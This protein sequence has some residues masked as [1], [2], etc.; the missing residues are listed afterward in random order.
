M[1]RKLVLIVFALLLMISGTIGVY[2]YVDTRLSE[3]TVYEAY[4]TITKGEIINRSDII[5]YNLTG[6]KLLISNHFMTVLSDI[7]GMYAAVNI[8]K[9]T[10]F[11]TSMLVDSKTK[12]SAFRFEV[13]EGYVYQAIE[14]SLCNSVGGIIKKGDFVNLI[15]LTQIKNNLE[16]ATLDYSSILLIEKVKVID[17]INKSGLD[18]IDAS[19]EAYYDGVPSVVIIEIPKELQLKVSSYKMIKL[20]YV[21]PAYKE[22]DINE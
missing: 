4:K 14:T 17:V 5:E 1:N 20:I 19:K 11:K 3:V 6:D 16:D 12:I 13:K 7:E 10:N 18:E 8:Q 9:G 22:G 2:F 21:T 15:G